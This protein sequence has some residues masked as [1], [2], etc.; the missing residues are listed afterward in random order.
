MASTLAT[1][2]GAGAAARRAPAVRP[3]RRAAGGRGVCWRVGAVWRRCARLATS[4]EGPA[5]PHTG[6]GQKAAPVLY[7]E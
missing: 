4:G 5:R 2:R 1:G 3:A 7:Y 6:K